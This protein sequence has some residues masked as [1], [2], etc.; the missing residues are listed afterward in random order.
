MKMD[1]PHAVEQSPAERSRARYNALVACAVRR[2]RVGSSHIAG[3]V[4]ESG[5]FADDDPIDARIAYFAS[6]KRI[7]S[8]I[9]GG[10]FRPTE[11]SELQIDRNTEI[12]VNPL[13]SVIGKPSFLGSRY[14]GYP[15]T[16]RGM[17]N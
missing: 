2:Q 14:P 3:T 1:F 7:L 17:E 13:A 15:E 11:T 10:A 9:G 4:N 8:D 12:D 16:L 5:M 6:A